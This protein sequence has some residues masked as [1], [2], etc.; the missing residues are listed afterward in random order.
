M[1]KT[2]QQYSFTYYEKNK[3]ICNSRSLK[4]YYKNRKKILAKNK[5]PAKKL[6]YREYA[7]RYRELNRERIREYQKKYQAKLR[8]RKREI[9][10]GKRKIRI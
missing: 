6:W 9:K 8:D 5:T 4:Y 2:Q 7:R 10:Y 1:K 3:E